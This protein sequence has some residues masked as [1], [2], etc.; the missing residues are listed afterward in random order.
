M[1]AIIIPKPVAQPDD[2]ASTDPQMKQ[3]LDSIET[4]TGKSTILVG[5]NVNDKY[6]VD[7]SRQNPCRPEVVLRP[8]NT[9]EVST[10]L[11]L[12]NQARQ[13]LVVQGGMTGLVGGATPRT[14]E[15]VLSLERLNGV[16]ELDVDSMTLTAKAGTPLET[17]QIAAREAGFMLPL[18]LGARGSC[19]IGGNIATNA[20]GNQVI[21]YGMTRSLVLDLEVVM[22]DGTII[23]SS[24]KL[25]KN[26]T[27]FDLKHLFIGSEGSLGVVTEAIL[28]LF[29]SRSSRQSALCA[30]SEFSDVISLLKSMKRK[31]PVISSFEAM[32]AS[33]YRY[34]VDVQMQT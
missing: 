28:R 16:V 17:L 1:T 3:L 22:A 9:G 30:M 26:N 11:R 25:L 8:A 7:W 15:W 2:L 32:W 6:A 34:A 10:I 13:P 14:G 20:G 18:D 23:S 29:P 5:E 24:N 27:G 31:L 4:E 12:C 19:T 21:Q 33:Y